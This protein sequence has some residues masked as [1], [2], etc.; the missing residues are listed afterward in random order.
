[1]PLMKHKRIYAV[2]LTFVQFSL[3]S[4]S[5]FGNGIK[6][7]DTNKESVQGL[8]FNNNN[9]LSSTA[10]DKKTSKKGKKVRTVDDVD[11]V[12]G[13]NIYIFAYSSELGDSVHYISAIQEL[14]NVPFLKKKKFLLGRENYSDQFKLHVMNKYGRS[15]QTATVFFDKKKNKAEKKMAKLRKAKLHDKSAVINNVSISDFSFS[16]PISLDKNN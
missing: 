4:S 6:A 11:H 10:K 13:K 14:N 1:M 7:V 16:I 8:Y 15:N 9:Q 5:S 3:A 12:V 2:L